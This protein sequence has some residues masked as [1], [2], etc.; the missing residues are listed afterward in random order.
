MTKSR[1]ILGP[2]FKWTDELVAELVRRYP[3]EKTDTVAQAL[4]CTTSAVFN[5]AHKLGLHKSPGFMAS[6]E[7][8]RIKKGEQR[9]QATQFRSKQAAWNKG[10]SYL[11]KGRCAETWFKQGHKPHTW[12][13]VGSY[14][15]T[16]DGTLQRKIGD[17]S[18]PNHKRWRSV[19]ELVWIEANGAVPA[20]HIVV[21]KSGC[22]TTELAEI[23]LDKIECISMAE[24][25]R[26]NMVHR[27]PAELKEVIRLKAAVS[28][29]INDRTRHEKQH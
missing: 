15:I 29:K 6:D 1:G 17:E 22:R 23:T 9:G 27:L 2:R 7:S 5:Q 8:G 13:P 10:V 18:G 20:K 3:H 25:M 21:F 14:R 19:H 4:G 12:Q 16:K 28:R 24:N 11:P 26:R